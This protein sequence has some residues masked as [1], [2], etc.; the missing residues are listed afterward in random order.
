M[1]LLSTS[2]LGQGKYS[3]VIIFNISLY[4]SF[5]INFYFNY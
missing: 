5:F 1:F 4:N 2:G 3:D